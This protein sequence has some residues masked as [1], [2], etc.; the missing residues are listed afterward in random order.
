VAHCEAGSP[1]AERPELA[2]ILKQHAHDLTSLSNEQARVV[3]A[4]SA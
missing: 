2:E 3:S 4:L 1:R